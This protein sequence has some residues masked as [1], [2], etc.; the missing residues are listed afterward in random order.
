MTFAAPRRIAV[1]LI[2]GRLGK[3]TGIGIGISRAIPS[4]V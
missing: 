4:R 2:I 1:V 3:L